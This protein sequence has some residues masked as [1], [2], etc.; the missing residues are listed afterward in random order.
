MR[1]IEA[2]VEPSDS[3]SQTCAQLNLCE[4]FTLI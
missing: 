4:I 3:A 2:N 1:R